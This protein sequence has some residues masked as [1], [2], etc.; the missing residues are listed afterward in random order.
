[1]SSLGKDVRISVF[2]GYK[3]EWRSLGRLESYDSSRL[4][5][6]LNELLAGPE[7]GGIKWVDFGNAGGKCWLEVSG[8]IIMAMW[9]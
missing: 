2:L 8:V 4:Q 9:W 3:E 5:V 7:L 6:F 1:M